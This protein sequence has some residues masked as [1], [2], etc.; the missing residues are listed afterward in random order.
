MISFL[1]DFISRKRNQRMLGRKGYIG[2]RKRRTQGDTLSTAAERSI[3]LAIIMLMAIWCVSVAIL[4]LRKDDVEDI[5]LVENQLAPTTIFSDLPSFSYEDKEATDQ[6]KQEAMD[7]IPLYYK[8]S[9]YQITRSLDLADKVF[10]LL[11][12]RYRALQ[13]NQPVTAEDRSPAG[14][15]I[16]KIPPA[17]LTMLYRLVESNE[18]KEKYLR[19]LTALLERGI[20]AQNEKDS[21]KVGQV[22]RIIITRNRIL[23]DRQL[24]EIMTPDK[25]AEQLSGDILKFYSGNDRNDF[26]RALNL[27][28]QSLIGVEGDLTYN[29]KYTDEERQKAAAEVIPVSIRFS[30]DQPIIRK[31]DVVTARI[32]D[33]LKQHRL[34]LK[35]AQ[36][37]HSM[38][39]RFMRMAVICALLMVITGIY[40]YHIHPEVARSNQKIWVVGTTVIIGMMANYGALELFDMLSP[41]LT[42]APRWSKDVLPLA[43]ASVLL[44]VTIG[45]RVAVYAGFFVAVIAALMLGDSFELVLKGMIVSAIAGFSVRYSTNYKSFFFRT[46]LTV[47]VTWIL[48]DNQFYMKF[49]FS[50]YT[51]IYAGVNAM[52]TAIAALL[53][54]FV[55]EFTFNVSTNMALL[56]LCD[57]NHPL[58]KRLQMEAPG[59]FHHSL[60]VATLAEQAA[61]VIGGNPIKARVGALF[62]DIGKL[63]KPEYFTENN[64]GNDKHRELHPRMSCLIILNHVKEGVDMA[65]KYKLKKIIRDTIEQHHG[66]DIVFYFYKRAMEESPDVSVVEGEYRYPGPLPHEKEVVVVSLADACEAASRSLQK[67]TPAKI[68]ALV[69]ELIRKRVRDRQLDDAGL[70]VRELAMVRDSFVKTLTTMLHGRITYPKDESD[71]EDDLFMASKKISAAESPPAKTDD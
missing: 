13:N 22:I 43:L 67:P 69:W 48:L 66:N 35:E 11:E 50:A 41:A 29:E 39:E 5:P 7:R 1:R 70:T 44:S 24:V 10:S 28:T 52:V 12:Q 47:F 53:L 8:I 23:K 27:L 57:Y 33:I 21:K 56:M 2:S 16:N 14:E 15:L 25:A 6:R 26:S 36:Q 45:L 71:D 32:L 51:P 17:G 4:T 63:V 40:I 59:T 9:S 42:L 3:F 49:V 61:K 58:L 37:M 65:I 18:Q 64:A 30:K 62:H 68:E 19:Q 38:W 20:M 60:T 54:L 55:L 31:N 34:A 46:L